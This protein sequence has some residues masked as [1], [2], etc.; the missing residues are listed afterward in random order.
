MTQ[1][2]SAGI[3][4]FGNAKGT[5]ITNSTMGDNDIGAYNFQTGVLPPKGAMAVF[6]GDKFVN[7]RFEGFAFDQ[8]NASLQSSTIAGGNIGV[9]ALQ[10]DGQQFGAVGLVNKVSISGTTTAAVDVDSDGSLND[11]QGKLTIENSHIS[12]NPGPVLDNSSN[13]IVIQNS[14]T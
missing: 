7:N 14:N 13:F 6:S 9:L 10:Y 11:I 1:T 5:S 12:G 2:Q 3:L 4:L 8:G